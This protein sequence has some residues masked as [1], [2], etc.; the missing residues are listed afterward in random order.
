VSARLVGL[1]RATGAAAIVAAAVGCAG[2]AVDQSPGG[3][4]GMG[5]P[6]RCTAALVLPPPAEIPEAGA[7]AELRVG[8]ALMGGP[9]VPELV[10]AVR[11]GGEPAPFALAA[12]DGSAIAVPLTAAGIYAI[13]VAVPRSQCPNATAI[14]SVRAQGARATRYRLRVASATDGAMREHAITVYGLADAF[15]GELALG[16][17]GD[18]AP[19]VVGAG[20]APA[21]VRLVPVAAPD[22]DRDLITDAEGRVAAPLMDARYHA[23]VTPLAPGIPPRRVED[24]H[25]SDEPIAS[26]AT[27]SI[28]GVVRRG[29]ARIAGAQV[30]LRMLASATA[31]RRLGATSAVPSTL[32][33]TDDQGEFTVLVDAADY[34]R[35]SD[36]A[37]DI[38]PPPATGLPRLV[39]TAAA[40]ELRAT[41]LDIAY[42]PT[43]SAAAL[44]GLTILRGA[45]PAA[46]ARVTL[47]G[48]VPAAGTVTGAAAVAATGI[49]RLSLVADGAGRLPSGTRAPRAS[50]RAVIELDPTQRT[51]ALLDTSGPLPATLAALDPVLRAPVVRTAAGVIAPGAA[52]EAIPVGALA[53][54]GPAVVV[55]AVADDTGRAALAL[56]AGGRYQLRA[57]DPVARHGATGAQ[58]EVAASD[59]AP[60]YALSRAIRLEGRIVGSSA[61]VVQLLCGACQGLERLRPIAEAVAAVDGAFV[62]VVPDPGRVTTAAGRDPG[63]RAA[64][65]GR[66]SSASGAPRRGG[67]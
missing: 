46:G 36:L 10:W 39:A 56:A 51:V 25:P 41:A 7:G 42:D 2:E 48:E 1:R 8:V 19:R 31:A 26:A 62:L 30:Q 40:A 67:R 34:D 4:G 3:D 6:Q 58:V 35:A 33:T 47:V 57:V 24:W 43:A 29:T 32:A 13:E 54:A 60:A 21:M 50:L 27:Y 55:R 61:A 49:A 44:D 52:I 65:A 18:P 66:G 28:T 63:A 23:L 37:V 15:V 5:S 9:G 20:A 17:A 22:A 38:A 45:G 59:V 16:A 53:Q 12:L 14:A 64:G 11:R